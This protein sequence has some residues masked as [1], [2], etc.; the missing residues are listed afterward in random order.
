VSIA[1]QTAQIITEPAERYHANTLY[2]SQSMLKTFLGRRSKAKAY[3]VDKSE[4][5][6]PSTVEHDKGTATHTAL[7]EPERFS[8]LVVTYPR[9]VL[10]KRGYATTNA[11]EAFFRENEAAGRK[12]LK[13]KDYEIV[14][15]MAA[16]VRTK[17]GEW[18]DGA[19]YREHSFYWECEET[20]LKSKMRLD[21]LCNREKRVILDLKTCPNSSAREFWRTAQKL[22]YW[23]QP[24]QYCEGVRKFFGDKEDPLFLFIAVEK[25]FPYATA[26][27]GIEPHSMREAKRKHLRIRRDVKKCLDT[28][29]WSESWERE[30]NW[31]E[32]QD[33]VFE[34]GESE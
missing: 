24:P 20:G 1:E 5:Q 18:L 7:I 9:D 34:Q 25:T 14:K 2:W 32:I 21:L 26:L 4:P 19:E 15:R 27:H 29:D 10:D 11:A 30:I 3:Y 23:L 12:V 33:W 16:S 6:P 22:G 13:E 17:C 8:E 31:M 28:G